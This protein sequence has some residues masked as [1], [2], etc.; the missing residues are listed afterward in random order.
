MQSIRSFTVRTDAEIARAH[1]A[2][3]DARQ[4]VHQVDGVDAVDFEVVVEAGLGYHRRLFQLEQLDQRPADDVEDF[5]AGL[6]GN[7]TWC[8]V[9]HRIR[10][11]EQPREVGVQTP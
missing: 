3:E 1:P 10:L 11:G 6:H 7:W 5:L 9:S 8:L 4:V 2:F